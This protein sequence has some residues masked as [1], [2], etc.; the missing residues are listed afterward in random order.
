M[1]TQL[2][3]K[4]STG[5]SISIVLIAVLFFAS[6]SIQ[7]CSDDLNKRSFKFEGVQ[8][9]AISQIISFKIRR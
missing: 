3:N 8:I 2:R 1:T 5:F 6:L 7:S 4:M 9:G